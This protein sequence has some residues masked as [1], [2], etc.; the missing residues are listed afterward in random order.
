VVLDCRIIKRLKSG[1]LILV[2][3]FSALP[4]FGCASPPV[5]QASMP[6]IQDVKATNAASI[7]PDSIASKLA[8]RPSGFTDKYQDNMAYV[9]G[10]KYISALGK[11]CRVIYFR[12]SNS[13]SKKIKRTACK[14]SDSADWV[15]NPQIIE[16]KDSQYDFGV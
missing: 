4:L 16:T 15:L 12:K 3:F 13:S 10:E 14:V 1:R 2:S 6:L 7:M 8:T 5:L 9:L 11:E